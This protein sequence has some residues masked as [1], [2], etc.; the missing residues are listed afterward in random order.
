MGKYTLVFNNLMC[1]S[2]TYLHVKI[3]VG[4]AQLGYDLD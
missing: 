2:V 1:S 4:T 3:N